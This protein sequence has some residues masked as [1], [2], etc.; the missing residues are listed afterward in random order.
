MNGPLSTPHSLDVLLLAEACLA[1][2]LARHYPTHYIKASGEVDVAYVDGGRF[3]PVELKWTRQLRPK[4][5]AQVGKYE[6]GLIVTRLDH[7]G[8]IAGVPTLPLP[9]FLFRLGPSPVTAPDRL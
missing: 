8:E 1:S 6:N 5:L 4:D 9:V 7:P 2:H 3:W